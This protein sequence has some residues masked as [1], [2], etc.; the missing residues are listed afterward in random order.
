MSKLIYGDICPDPPVENKNLSNYMVQ[1]ISIINQ[2]K[3]S[4]NKD[5]VQERLKTLLSEIKTINT[6]LFN[7]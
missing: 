2:Y 4:G 7:S 1:Y 6:K 5:I 3:T